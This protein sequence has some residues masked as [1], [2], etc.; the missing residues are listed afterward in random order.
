MK[1]VAKQLLIVWKN[2]GIKING[3]ELLS[4]N[5]G[6]IGRP[7]IAKE[8]I[9]AGYEF[10]MHEIFNKYLVNGSPAYIRSSILSVQEGVDLL[11]NNNA[12]VVLAHPI[13]IRKTKI[14]DLLTNFKF[15]E[16]YI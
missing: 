10:S 2:F 4:K 5:N 8:I 15:D 11:R 9:N 12:T 7:H 16:S 3:D 6:M 13:L 14:E 1:I